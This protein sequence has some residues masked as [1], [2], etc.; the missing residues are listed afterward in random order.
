[1]VWAFPA[2]VIRDV[3]P[4]KVTLRV[5][6]Y[7]KLQHASDPSALTPRFDEGSL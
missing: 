4:T 3:P 7:N 2:S 6:W 1:M 5:G